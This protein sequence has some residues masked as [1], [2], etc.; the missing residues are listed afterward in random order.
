MVLNAASPILTRIGIIHP[1]FPRAKDLFVQNGP[2]NKPA[3][4]GLLQFQN[5]KSPE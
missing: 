4:A 3:C 1:A 2:P 5:K